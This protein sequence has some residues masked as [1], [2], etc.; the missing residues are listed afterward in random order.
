[1]SDARITDEFLSTILDQSTQIVQKQDIIVGSDRVT[2]PI[3]EQTGPT[4]TTGDSTVQQI[5]ERIS[6]IDRMLYEVKDLM[7]RV[8]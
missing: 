2:Q 4:Q 5:L 8:K 6:T 3:H 7:R 1:M